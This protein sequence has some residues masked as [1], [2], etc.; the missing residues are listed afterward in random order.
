MNDAPVLAG[1]E[2]AALGYTENA[3]ATAI[4]GTLTLSDADNANLIGATVTISAN[5]ANGQDLLAFTDQLGITGSWIAAT[6]ELTLSG[7]TSVANYQTAVRA[8]PISTPATTPAR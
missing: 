8:S 6:G 3:A 1:I 5:Y 4:T 7:T 2:G